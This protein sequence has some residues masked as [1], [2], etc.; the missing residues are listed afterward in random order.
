MSLIDAVDRVCARLAQE[1]GTVVHVRGMT[2]SGLSRGCLESGRESLRL[3]QP[4]PSQ[5]IAL[6][7]DCGSVMTRSA[8]RLNTWSA[9]RDRQNAMIAR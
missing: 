5:N 6:G 9:G 4:H 2:V 7:L 1:F 8:G 3:R